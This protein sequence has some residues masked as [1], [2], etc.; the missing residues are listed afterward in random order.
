MAIKLNTNA[1]GTGTKET[2]T[3]SSTS[4]N[5][6]YGSTGAEV[7]KLQ[8]AL[9]FTGSDVDGKF[10]PKT[11]QAVKDYQAANG[12]KVDGIAGKNTLGKLYSNTAPATPTPAAPAQPQA[13]ATNAPVAQEPSTFTYEDY[14][15]GQMENS[16]LTNEAWNILQQHE[17]SKPG[18]WS[19]PY[20]DKWMGYLEQYENRDPFSYDFNSDALYQQYKDQYI[21]QGQMAM[22]DTMG[23]AASMTGGYGNSY[24]QTVGQQAYNQQLNQL[25]N[26]MP[27]LY[28]MAYD[29][30]G[31]EGQEMLDMFNM[32]LGLSE[33][34]YSRYQSELDNWYQEAGR[35]TD[36]YNTLYSQDW[37]KY[38]LGE[39]TRFNVYNTGRSEAYD[40]YQ[41]DIDRDYQKDRDQVA[42]QQWQATFDENKRQADRS[43]ALSASNSSGGNGG[44]GDPKY[45]D[46][47]VGD[48]AYNTMVKKVAGVTSLDEL[49][50]LVK[51]WI[52]MKYDPAFIN[53]L[54]AGKA[55][56]FAAG[57]VTDTTVGPT[58]D[59]WQEE[60]AR[61]RA[62]V[63]PG[64]TGKIEQFAY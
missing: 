52:S 17:A 19:D 3:T 50:G 15:A 49:Q 36:N 54:T 32:Y 8:E 9:G 39:N 1:A 5:L 58:V 22:M 18:E 57:N 16:D 24:A 55:A 28:Q 14:T 63:Y 6:K 31:Q 40:S 25:N 61:R 27:E 10:G 47:E 41:K 33:Q 30:Y 7:K 11:Q 48:A 46:I 34:D 29:R 21:Q 56:E 4:T 35:L 45:K 23:Q 64:V 42:D 13:P 62:A 59:P 2:T 26:I 37:D 53:E 12:L 38:V 51:M 43:Y 44:N 60:Q 20:R